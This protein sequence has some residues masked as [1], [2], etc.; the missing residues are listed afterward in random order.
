MEEELI[1]IKNKMNILEEKYPN[2]IEI[3]KKY[4]QVKRQSLL[5]GI[6]ECDKALDTIVKNIE[7]DLNKETITLLYLLNNRI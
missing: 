6:K 4:I 5:I 1:R 3:W 2:L 7:N